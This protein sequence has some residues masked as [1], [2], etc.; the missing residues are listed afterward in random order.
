[1]T[2][3]RPVSI[4]AYCPDHDL[5]PLIGVV[6]ELQAH[7]ARLYDRMR[8]PGDM[9]TSYVEHLMRECGAHAGRI[10]VAERG[11][12]II[13]YATIL[14]RI[15]VDCADEVAHSYAYVGDLAVSAPARG[16]GIGR[17]LLEHCEAE[18]RR[19][20]ACYMRVTALAANTQACDVYRTFGF[21]DLFIDFEKPL[22]RE[23]SPQ[24]D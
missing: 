8:S 21:R 15:D 13:G 12:E 23:D 10:L 11:G 17:L 24:C 20:G 7:E 5:D 2:E 4:R 19:C 16:Q 14:T 1:M 6:R 9:G 3:T 22:T 18:A